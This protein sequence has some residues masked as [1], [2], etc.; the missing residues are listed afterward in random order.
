L[1]RR[2]KRGEGDAATQLYLRYA[3]RLTA[4]A[5]RQTSR[6]LSTRFDPEDVIQSVFRTF[7]RR[8]SDG[9][10]D[11]PAGEEL[12]QLLLVIALNK[13]RQLGR[14]HH[15]QRRDVDKTMGGEALAGG[16]LAAADM[17]LRM[18]EMVIDEALQ[19]LPDIQRQMIE[20]RI[21]GHSVAEIAE[22]TQRC[23]RTVERVMRQ[24]R[25]HISD[26]IAHEE[27][28]ADA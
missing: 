2:F 18:L 15:Q 10:F 24:F 26:Y 28:D 7:F 20:L 21:Q 17:S 4:F 8:A 13:V 23:R 1:L 27:S 14:F 19:Q 9:T 3:Q 5:Q 25:D 22:V 16:Q 12:W 11:V 6:Q